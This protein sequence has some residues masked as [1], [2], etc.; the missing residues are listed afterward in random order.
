MYHTDIKVYTDGRKTDNCATPEVIMV[1]ELQQ[2]QEQKEKALDRYKIIFEILLPRGWAQL[3]DKY[4]A[5]F[6]MIAKRM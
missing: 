3:V 4:L 2:R 5:L 6:K 1:E